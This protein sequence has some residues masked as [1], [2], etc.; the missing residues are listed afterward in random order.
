[1]P[2]FT[3]TSAE[4]LQKLSTYC[5]TQVHSLFLHIQHKSADFELRKILVD[6]LLQ[7]ETKNLF[8]IFGFR[9][10]TASQEVKWPTFQDLKKGFNKP[11]IVLGP[12]ELRRYH[13]KNLP[14]LSVG[15]RAWQKHAHR[16]SE[17]WW[18]EPR[19]TEQ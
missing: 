1:M 5:T 19:G 18:G 2:A 12:E 4:A 8:R 11:N 3:D 13:A 6:F 17:G 14:Q 16:S 9:L 10:T 7:I 15:A